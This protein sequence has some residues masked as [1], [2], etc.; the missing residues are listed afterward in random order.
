[1]LFHGLYR[2]HFSFLMN[3]DFVIR[4]KIL[5]V[6]TLC[7]LFINKIYF[8][9][10][11]QLCIIEYELLNSPTTRQPTVALPYLDRV[12]TVPYG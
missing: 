11:F 7:T 12:G 9:S 6:I 1:M 10:Q 8:F 4:A 5:Y 3:N 2:S